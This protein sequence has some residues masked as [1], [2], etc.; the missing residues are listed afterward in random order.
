MT[1]MGCMASNRIWYD[2]GESGDPLKKKLP[3]SV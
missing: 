1:V 3:S 2:L